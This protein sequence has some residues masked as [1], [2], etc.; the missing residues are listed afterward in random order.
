MTYGYPA[1]GGAATLMQQTATTKALLISGV[2]TCAIAAVL[3]FG[4]MN[5][6][7]K[8]VAEA[9][10]AKQEKKVTTLLYTTVILAVIGAVLLYFYTQTKL[11]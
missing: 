10:K 3:L 1:F 8:E 11:Q 4:Y 6:M 7:N 9:D 2:L 5:E